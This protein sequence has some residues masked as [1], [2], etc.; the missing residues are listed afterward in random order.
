MHSHA[1]PRLRM[2]API[3]ARIPGTLAQEGRDDFRCGAD[4]PFLA[5]CASE[6]G[7]TM[8]PIVLCARE[9]TWNWRLNSSRTMRQLVI[10]R[11]TS[12][13]EQLAFADSFRI[14]LVDAPGLE[15]G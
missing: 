3:G 1:P 12:G 5:A 15:P 7:A 4:P 14:D 2:T 11:Q 8:I 13:L 9:W 6:S 10:D